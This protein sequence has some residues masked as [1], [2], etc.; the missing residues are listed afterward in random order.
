MTHR[1]IARTTAGVA[2]TLAIGALTA[3]A[4]GTAGAAPATV[5]WTKGATTYTRTISDATPTVGETIT[6]S[7]QIKRTDSTDETI[8]WFRDM[9]PACLTYVTNSA[10]M[11]DDSG[12]N[13]V[14]PYLDTKFPDYI[15]GDFTATDYQ[16]VASSSPVTFSAK[17][18]V[19]ASCTPG[20]AMTDGIVY[21]SSLGRFDYAN[22]GPSITVTAATHT[23]VTLAPV[24]G[25]T[26]G[27][28]TTLTATVSP[29]NAGGTVSFSDGTTVLGTGTVNASGT[30]TLSWTP[31]VAGS[32][33]ITA[34]YSGT[35]TA[36]TTGTVTVAAAGTSTGTGSAVPSFLV[37]LSAGN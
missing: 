16:M 9:H 6:V 26:V 32:H 20:T 29:A 15:A 27:Q 11:T 31:T 2:T 7:T 21:L 34:N 22:Q 10:T 24:T 3:L 12:S 23:T 18:K 33:S 4:A 14:E 28:A 30:A 36:T 1:V 13:P 17:Y 37:S 5:T 35:G 25:A 8:D 19:G